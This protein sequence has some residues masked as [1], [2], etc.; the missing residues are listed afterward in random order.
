MTI[1][2][3][4]SAEFLALKKT[5]NKPS[6]KAFLCCAKVDT[7]MVVSSAVFYSSE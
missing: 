1:N 3:I 6:I 7:Y 5:K 4:I 2:L